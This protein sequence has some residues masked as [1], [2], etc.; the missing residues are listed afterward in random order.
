MCQKIFTN[1]QFLFVLRLS[2]QLAIIVFNSYT[3]MSFYLYSYFKSIIDCCIPH[4]LFVVIFNI[5]VKFVV[6][7]CIYKV[8]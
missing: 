4:S 3:V 6:V 1:G 7:N 8:V 5:N 2:K